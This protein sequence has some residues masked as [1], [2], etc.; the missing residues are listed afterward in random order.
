MKIKIKKGGNAELKYKILIKY[1]S[2]FKK[3]FYEFY[4][5]TDDSSKEVEFSTTDVE[6][7]NKVMKELDKKVGHENLRVVVDLT[8]DVAIQVD[9]DSQYQTTTS[10][11]ITDIYTNAYSEVFG[12]DGG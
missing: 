3:D 7:L 4:K 6:E 1:T 9:K 5:V 2:T 10:E 12:E 11:D 8:Y